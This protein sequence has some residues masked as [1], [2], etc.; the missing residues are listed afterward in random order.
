MI[1]LSMVPSLWFRVMNHRVLAYKQKAEEYERSG[2]DMFPD[3]TSE[4]PIIKYKER[5][6]S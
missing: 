5:M 6:S 2:L 1:L 4:K 3:P